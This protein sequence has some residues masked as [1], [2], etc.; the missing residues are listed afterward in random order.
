MDTSGTKE[1]PITGLHERDI[2]GLIALSK[3]VGWDY[4]TEELKTILSSGVVMGHKNEKGEVVSSAAIIPYDTASA[5]LGMVI[6]NDQYR[7]QGLG[8]KAVQSCID[9][10]SADT[11]IMLIA[12]PE[13]QPLYEKLGFKEVGHVHKMIGRYSRCFNPSFRD[14]YQLDS[15]TGNEIDRIAAIDQSAFGEAR[16]RFLVNRIEQSHEAAVLKDSAGQI[17]G[18]G[19]S[20]L[21]PVYLTLGPI[22]APDDRSALD[23]VDQLARSHKG[24]LRMDIPADN[25]TFI[26][27]L[28]GAGFEEVSKPPVMILHANSL[29]ERNGHLYGIAA[30]I[31]G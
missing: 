31:F 15:L 19:L 9:Q 22:V 23:L 27:L 29:P 7:G 16:K 8:K 26:E 13:G 25:Q 18:Y 14:S 5:S 1:L 2:P 20:V 4:H 17:V 24:E 30:Q 12:T 6:V 11:A 28:K 3:S 21:G 10:V